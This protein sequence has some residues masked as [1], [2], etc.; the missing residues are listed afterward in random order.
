MSTIDL[1]DC[2]ILKIG[3]PTLNGKTYPMEVCKEFVELKKT[4]YGQLNMPTKST[5]DMGEV[6]HTISN[7]RISNNTVLGDVTIL[8]TPMGQILQE[9]TP[10]T[11]GFGISGIYAADEDNVVTKLV[12]SSINVVMNN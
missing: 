10:G 3:V 8:H 9:L 11:Y 12:L 1:F 2:E 4:W 7:L 6:S 5:I